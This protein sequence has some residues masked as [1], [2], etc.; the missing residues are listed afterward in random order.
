M[1]VS[2]WEN[3]LF[4]WAIVHGY[5]SHN[6]RVYPIRSH[7]IPLNPIKPPFSYG[8]PMVFL[9]FKIMLQQP[10]RLSLGISRPW[11]AHCVI[12]YGTGAPER[13]NIMDT[14]V[15]RVTLGYQGFL[16]GQVQAANIAFWLQFSSAAI[17]ELDLPLF[18]QPSV[19]TTMTSLHACSR[20]TFFWAMGWR[21]AGSAKL[22]ATSL[23]KNAR[24]SC[25]I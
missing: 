1:E 20:I 18:L 10:A 2:S 25:Q 11:C 9:W 24:C 21:F 4:L 23:K 22:V 17:W 5:V 15:Q 13:L 3:H 14:M 6:Q 12:C 7:K 8:F 19:Y 16:E